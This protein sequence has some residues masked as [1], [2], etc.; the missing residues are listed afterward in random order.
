MPTLW[1]TARDLLN[2]ARGGQSLEE[3]PQPQHLKDMKWEDARNHASIISH[4]HLD[5]RPGPQPHVDIILIENG[6]MFPKT[7]TPTCLHTLNSMMPLE[8]INL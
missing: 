5:H 8:Q 7:S 4:Q 3:S 6:W 2:S 1:I